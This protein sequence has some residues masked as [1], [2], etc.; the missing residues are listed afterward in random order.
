MDARKKNVERHFLPRTSSGQ[1]Y[2]IDDA[3]S[4][5]SAVGAVGVGSAN[6]VDNNRETS[7][8]ARKRCVSFISATSASSCHPNLNAATC[9]RAATCACST[10]PGRTSELARPMSLEEAPEEEYCVSEPAVIYTPTLE[11]CWLS[12]PGI[13]L[14]DNALCS[15]PPDEIEDIFCCR[16]T[17]LR[18]RLQGLEGRPMP[19]TSATI[20]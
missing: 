11:P 16:P 15:R 8:C 7:S 17:Y 3:K 2:A 13:L 10:R 5:I 14:R 9:L 1:G 6:Q 4:V 12:A 18:R 20:G 19:S